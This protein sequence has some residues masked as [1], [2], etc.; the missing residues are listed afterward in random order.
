MSWHSVRFAVLLEPAQL[1]PWH[2]AFLIYVGFFPKYFTKFGV[3]ELEMET[4]GCPK[5]K[6]CY[7]RFFLSSERSLALKL[8]SCIPP[9]SSKKD[10]S[11]STN[12][13]DNL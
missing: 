11:K 12:Q 7:R 1:G 5:V 6:G 2:S 4:Q 8:K 9:S 13:T 10:I 3:L